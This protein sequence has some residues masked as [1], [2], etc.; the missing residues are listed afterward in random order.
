MSY[1]ELAA[2]AAARPALPSPAAR[3]AP[4]CGLYLHDRKVP[5]DDVFAVADGSYHCGAKSWPTKI[6]LL[7]PFA[8]LFSRVV[9]LF[10]F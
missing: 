8:D 1:A 3:L 7:S 6:Q 5:D 9:I 2:Q 10:V 4:R